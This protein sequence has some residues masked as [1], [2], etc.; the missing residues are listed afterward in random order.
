MAEVVKMGKLFIILLVVGIVG[1]GM[2]WSQDF[3]YEQFYHH[4]VAL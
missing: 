2:A 1:T 3:D 4:V